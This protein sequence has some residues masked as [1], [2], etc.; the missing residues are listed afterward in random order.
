MPTY[1]FKDLKTGKEYDKIMSY[2]DMLK[3]K[4]KPRTARIERKK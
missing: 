2:E 1:T 4:K 3:Y